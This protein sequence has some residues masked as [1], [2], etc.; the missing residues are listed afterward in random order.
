MVGDCGFDVLDRHRGLADS[1]HAG[2]FAGSGAHP[3]GE[4][5]E[6]V[7][8]VEPFQGVFPE[9]AVDEVVPLRDQV[10]DRAARPLVAAAHRVP[11]VAER[12]AAVH[13]PRALVP[14]LLHP[15]VQVELVPVLHPFER[16]SILRQLPLDLHESRWFAHY[17]TCRRVSRC[18]DFP[19][20]ERSNHTGAKTKALAFATRA[21]TVP[22]DSR[23]PVSA[24]VPSCV[25][26]H[27]SRRFTS[28]AWTFAE[29]ERVSNHTGA[30]TKFSRLA[31]QPYLST[32]G[33][34]LARVSCRSPSLRPPC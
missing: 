34:C 13:A 26:L 18:L 33:P 6:V 11:G 10:V 16:R 1:E 4:L 8:L 21:P 2:P 24:R 15:H 27:E 32:A 28:S 29:R 23:S 25:D 30:K 9:A 22:L 31:R 19:E 3:P 5:G 14:Q 20:R 7:G 12:D 17:L